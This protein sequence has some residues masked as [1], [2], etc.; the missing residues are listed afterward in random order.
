MLRR[1]ASSGVA[2]ASAQTR[3]ESVAGRRDGTIDDRSHANRN[4]TGRDR[5]SAAVLVYG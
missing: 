4:R 5:P 3:L 1:I 2:A